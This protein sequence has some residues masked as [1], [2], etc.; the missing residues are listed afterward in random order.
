MKRGDVRE[1]GRVFWGMNKG[2]PEWRTPE[3]FAK[4]TQKSTE[5]KRLRRKVGLYFVQEHKSRWGCKDCGEKDPVVLSL[6]HKSNKKFNVADRVGGNQQQLADEINK[7][8]IL[9][10]NCHA[11]RHHKP[12]DLYYDLSV[13][14]MI[15]QFRKELG[16]KEKKDPPYDKKDEINFEQEWDD[17]DSTISNIP[18]KPTYPEEWD[19]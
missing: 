2:R 13:I 14:K 12:V 16:V 4:A 17:W 7:C 1:D 9:C 3:A 19:V 15:T 5:N 10:H 11:K 18:N 8:E 6:H